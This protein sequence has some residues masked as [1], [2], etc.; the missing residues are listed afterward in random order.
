MIK[1]LAPL[2]VVI[3]LSPLVQAVEQLPPMAGI[4][5][6]NSMGFRP[7]VLVDAGWSPLFGVNP[8]LDSMYYSM[9]LTC[10]VAARTVW[11][12]RQAGLRLKPMKR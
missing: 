3:P 8:R 7:A 12:H 9:A 6:G 5:L 4:S 10:M 1:R 2:L 11:I